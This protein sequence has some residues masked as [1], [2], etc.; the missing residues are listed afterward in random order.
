MKLGPGNDVHGPPYKYETNLPD[1][2][3]LLKDPKSKFEMAQLSQS[4]DWLEISD[5]SVYVLRQK[6][7]YT[8]S[9]HHIGF[10]FFRKV[11]LE[12]IWYTA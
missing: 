9:G 8:I 1:G 3:A 7:S 12:Y 11:A 6:A 10:S 5:T 2:G 4:R